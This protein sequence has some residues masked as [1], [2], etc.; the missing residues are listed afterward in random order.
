M[1]VEML[2][3]N[4]VLYGATAQDVQSAAVAFVLAAWAADPDVDVVV[5]KLPQVWYPAWRTPTRCSR[6]FRASPR[7]GRAL[8]GP[9]PPWWRRR[10][11]RIDTWDG[12]HPNARGELV[13]AAA[14]PTLAGLSVGATYP[15]PLPGRTPRASTPAHPGG[16][17]RRLRRPAELGGVARP[18][19][20]YVWLRDVTDGEDWHRLPGAPCP[21]SLGAGRPRTG[22]TT[23]VM[24][25][26]VKGN[27][28][29]QDD[30]IRSNV[31]AFRPM[32]H[33]PRPGRPGRQGPRPRAVTVSWTAPATP[34]ASWRTLPAGTGPPSPG[35]ACDWAPTVAGARYVVA[36]A[37]HDATL[38]P[39]APGRPRGRGPRPAAPSTL[40]AR[41]SDG[42][43]RLR[44]SMVEDATRYE[45]S[46]RV[47]GSGAGSGGRALAGS[48]PVPRW[49]AASWRLRVRAWHQQLRGGAARV[50]VPR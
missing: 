26:P 17:R 14:W 4:D 33:R 48:T 7:R 22:T 34:R 44:W 30:V 9:A 23:E 10:C 43:V 6:R 49:R 16:D 8:A 50:T 41:R 37:L 12:T 36:A 38:G 42:S 39:G 29:A 21:A 20:E 45:V 24:L 2:G 3:I 1:V 35:P 46:R 40:T 32:A 11:W 13:L 28:A 18:D 27:L 25:Q 47:S 19:H 5:A 15:R 31:V